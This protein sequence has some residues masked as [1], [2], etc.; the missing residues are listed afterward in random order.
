MMKKILLI[1]LFSFFTVAFSQNKSLDYRSEIKN[2][3]TYVENTYKNDYDKI[4]SYVK[5]ESNGKIFLIKTEDIYS[6]FDFE[7]YYAYDFLRKD[8]KVVYIRKTPISQSG[9]SAI[10]YDYYFNNEG[11][12][13]GAEKFVSAFYG[14]NSKVVNYALG[15]ELS[16]KTDKLERVSEIYTDDKDKKIEKNSKLYKEAVENG[17]ISSYIDGM[18]K[19]SFRDLEGF[20]K[21]EK[22]KYYRNDEKE[23]SEPKKILEK[24][25]PSIGNLLKGRG[26]IGDP[27]G[28]DGNEDSR[29]GVDRKLIT[30]IPGTMG[31]GGKQ[32]SH[33]CSVSGTINIS[34]FVNELGN[35]ISAR[36]IS[37]ISDACVV[38]T[39]VAWVKQYVKAEEST[40]TSRGTYKITF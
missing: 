20:M 17:L 8:D 28:G 31:R 38:S 9:D 14:E 6:E 5:N 34:Y 33:N 37:G 7:F 26:N 39:S 36:R 12:L 32:P 16:D 29:I 11:R 2:L 19:I 4:K 18:D 3:K 24:E 30:F 1:T 27:L 15:Y 13:I 23:N 35:V 21:A 10:F 40:V 25:K 22:I